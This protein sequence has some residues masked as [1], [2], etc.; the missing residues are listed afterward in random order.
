[1]N[2]R[3][4]IELFLGIYEWKSIILGVIFRVSITLNTQGALLCVFAHSGVAT[5]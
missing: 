2:T 5:S 3:N 1:M 4:N